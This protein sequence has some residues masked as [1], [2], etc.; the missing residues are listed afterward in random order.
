VRPFRLRRLPTG[1]EALQHSREPGLDVM[2][3]GEKQIEARDELLRLATQDLLD[4]C[5]DF[6]RLEP[7]SLV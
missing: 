6:F 4:A 5:D 7:L 2:L 3:Q 1:P